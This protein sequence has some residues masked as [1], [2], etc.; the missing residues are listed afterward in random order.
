MSTA[1]LLA[2]AAIAGGTIFLGLPLGRVRGLRQSTRTLFNAAAAGILVFLLAEVL[3][4]GA[5][6]VEHSLEAASDGDGAWG[7]FGT[8]IVVFGGGVAAALLG[9]SY[10]QR[11]TERRHTAGA[12][13]R[14]GGPV[15]LSPGRRTALLI[16]VGIGFHNFAEGLAIGQ[17]AASGDV[18]LALLLI[19]GFALHNGTEGF[20]IVAPLS[21]EETRPSIGFLATLGLIGGAP[22][23]VG[24][25]IGR[26]IVNETLSIGFLALA[27]GSILFVLVQL[28]HVASKS[29][30][31]D[32]I[33]WG[34]L[35]GLV[36]GYGT[37]FVVAAAGA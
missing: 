35:A 20:G 9:L 27:G 8:K 4:G 32:L 22:T 1:R 15:S 31:A 34:L 28:F 25:I 13:D 10:Y 5:E 23:F 7:D 2:L 21:D 19:I 11:W 16:A 26:T 30:R 36:L 3:T 33:S 29:A 18:S 37:D 6:G 12:V 14:R 24:T 17:S